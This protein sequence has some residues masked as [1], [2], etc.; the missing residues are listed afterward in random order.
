[1]P[2]FAVL[3][4][5]AADSEALRDAHRPAHRAFLNDVDH[6][7]VEV[8]ATGPWATGEPGALIIASGP[9][10]QAVAEVFDQ[11]P[12]HQVAAVARREIREWTQVRTPWS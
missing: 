7:A 1:M 3:Y 9:D 12:F 10:E 2:V 11:D 8:L 5:Y 4:S 6:G